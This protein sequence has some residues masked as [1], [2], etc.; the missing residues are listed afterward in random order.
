MSVDMVA[1]RAAAERYANLGFSYLP[2]KLQAKVPDLPSWSEYQKR[3]PTA[4]EAADWFSRPQNLGVIC[5][6]ISGG[7]RVLDWES[8]DALVYCLGDVADLARHTPVSSTGRGFHTYTVEKGG[9]K[10][11]STSY[12][13]KGDAKAWLPLDVQGEG[14]YV[15]APPSVHPN[16]RTYRFLSEWD[17]IL[18]ASDESLHADLAKRAEEWPL[19][20]AILPAWKEGTRQNLTLGFA[21]VLRY[22]A[23]FA[24]DRIEEIVERVCRVAHDPELRSRL[25][26]VRSTLAKG[27]DETAAQ[28]W[29][30]EELYRTLKARVPKRR[31]KTR[32]GVGKGAAEHAEHVE[33]LMRKFTFATMADT[34]EI[35]VY[36]NGV[37]RPGAESLIRADVEVAY[38]EDGDSAK[39]NVADETVD[40]IRRRTYTDR[41]AFNR[42][43]KLCLQN[44]VLDLASLSVAP[45][46]TNDQFTIQLPVT[47]DQAADCQRFKRFLEE[48]LPDPTSR[49]TIKRVF[50]YCLEAGNRYQVAFMFVGE[51]DNGKTTLLGVLADMLGRGNIT[52]ETFQRLSENRFAASRLWDKLAN[53][54]AD[55]PPNAVRHADTF[56]SLTG[57]DIMPGERK[58]HDA[59]DFINPAKLIFA[60]NVLPDVND[61]TF[62]FWRRWIMVAFTV[63]FAGREDRDLPDKLRTELSGILNW[64][65]EGLRELREAHGFE[66]GG[67]A[68]SLMEDWKR[69]A[70]SLYWFISE[71]VELDAQSGISKDDFYEVYVTFCEANSARA[72]TRERVGSDLR[73]LLPSVRQEYPRREGGRRMYVWSGIKWSARAQ[74]LLDAPTPSKPLKPEG[75]QDVLDGG[76]GAGGTSGAGG[77]K[78]PPRNDPEKSRGDQHP[79]FMLGLERALEVRRH[80]PKRPVHFIV[81]DLLKELR[82][83][84]HDPDIDQLTAGVIKGMKAED[85]GRS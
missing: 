22:R 12:Q 61:R 52:T 71:C 73:D 19:V 3:H 10:P 9:G 41:K 30:G 64:S 67:F 35:Y 43:R 56:K 46:R 18:E 5:G 77:T 36:D 2:L 66:E 58:Y 27:E 37:Y 32:P 21:K 11:R 81:A 34:G 38:F 79:D 28:E 59:F 26:A 62:A 75:R 85:G 42:A 24:A 48:I 44:G 40:A 45:H 57:G 31:D 68:D 72:K 23:G 50:G 51:G 74:T 65:L 16:G 29:L 8:G 47:Y 7:L 1:L 54:C 83:R 39:K 80:D 53:I 6:S 82:G 60:A 78:L 49:R 33:R 69:R 84:G 76:A 55:I 15:V 63:N 20:E 25:E 14:K 70:D 4:A 13:R 17:G